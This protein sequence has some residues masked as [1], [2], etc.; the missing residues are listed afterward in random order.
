MFGGVKNSIYG[1]IVAC[2]EFR[3][4]LNSCNFL[5][6]GPYALVLKINTMLKITFQAIGLYNDYIIPTLDSQNRLIK[7]ALSFTF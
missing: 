5:T 1:A 2:I 3:I 6:Q 4:I 7:L